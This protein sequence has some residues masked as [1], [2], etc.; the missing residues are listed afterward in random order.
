MYFGRK[1]PENT[2]NLFNSKRGKFGRQVIPY[3]IQSD[4]S[5]QASAKPS[6]Q[7][8]PRI[9]D[10]Y[11]DINESLIKELKRDNQK[12][13]KAITE[14]KNQLQN[15][16]NNKKKQADDPNISFSKQQFNDNA[17]DRVDTKTLSY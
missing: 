10:R 15:I 17:D 8:T 6:K 9:L 14:D 1:G 3:D 11:D 16:L 5:N 2:L 12:Y 4:S 13:K 7:N